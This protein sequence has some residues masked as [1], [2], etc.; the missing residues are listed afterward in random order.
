[1]SPYRDKVKDREWHRDVMRKRRA[2]GLCGRSAAFHIFE[3]D[4]FRCQYCGKTPKDGI[5][6]EVDHIIPKCLG[7]ND[8]DDNLITSCAQCNGSQ[9]RHLLSPSAEQSIKDR[10]KVT[11]KVDADGNVIYEEG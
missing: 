1:M 4:N 8:S 5:Q 6:L 3:R 2:L 9:S 7:G 11:P 10:C